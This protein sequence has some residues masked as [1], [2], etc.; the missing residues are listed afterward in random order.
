VPSAEG[1]LCIHLCLSGRVKAMSLLVEWYV[2]GGFLN[3][4]PFASL[5]PRWRGRLDVFS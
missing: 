5:G 4:G 2:G 1:R 3:V